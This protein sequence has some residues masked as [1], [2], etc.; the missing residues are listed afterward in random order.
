MPLSIPA[1]IPALT[2]PRVTILLCTYNGA[3]HL[4]AQLASYVDQTYTSWDLWVSDDG[5][6]DDTM[7]ILLAFQM[8]HGAGR[9][10]HILKRPDTVSNKGPAGNFMW[11]LCAPD[12]PDQAVS[13]SDQDDVWWPD[14]LARG[15]E[16]MA[17][18]DGPVLYGAQSVHTNAALNPIGRSTPPPHPPSFGNALVQNIVSGHSAMLNRAGLALV[19]ATGIPQDIHYHDWWL[20]Q[21]VTGVGGI[22]K[23]D[24]N[25]VLFYRQHGDN[26]MGAHQG[27]RAALT[28]LTQV[29]GHTYGRWIAANTA[30]L[31]RVPQITPEA[32]A[33]LDDLAR[34][35]RCIGLKRARYFRRRA[36]KRQTALAQIFL[37]IAVVL[38]RV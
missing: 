2:L 6:T 14:K 25:K 8:D 36:I 33:T 30:A 22:V 5:S 16:Q 31:D 32:R 18:R 10:I 1:P 15:M 29:F 11:L 4:E 35:P 3:A 27:L 19:R 38:G 13:I 34:A 20:Y 7:A 9:D 17:A 12:L 21:L 37:L 26:A 24:S 23:I 28:R